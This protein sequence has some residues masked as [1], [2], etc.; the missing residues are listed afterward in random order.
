MDD[1][2]RGEDRTNRGVSLI[3]DPRDLTK[4]E[5]GVFSRILIVVQPLGGSTIT[6]GLKS[7]FQ[8]KGPFHFFVDFGRSGTDEWETL[9]QSPIVDG[10]MYY[11]TKQRHW[12]HLADWYYR[13]RLVLPSVPDEHGNPTVHKSQPQHASGIWAKRDWLIAREICRKEYLYQRKRVNV[14]ASGYILKRRRWGTP[15]P[16]CLE[17][18]TREVQ[19]AHCEICYGTGFVKGYFPA[20]D[21]TVSYLNQWPRGFKRD[22]QISLRNDVSRIGRAVNYPYLD[23]HD[24]FVRKDSGERFVLWE[25]QNMAEVGQIPIVVFLE[26]RLAPTTDILYTVPL[27]GGPSS[28]SSPSSSESSGSTPSGTNEWRVGIENGKENW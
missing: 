27:F 9:N 17:F 3:Y 10:C 19:N 16:V 13:L 22:P 20:I 12:D 14:T 26:L 1:P 6:W 28:S 23:K 21:F 5:C 4:M 15:C 25:I 24:I 2:I 18:D 11:D 8:A 7:G